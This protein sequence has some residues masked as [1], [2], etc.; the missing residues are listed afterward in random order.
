MKNTETL[1][2]NY[3]FRFVLTKGKYYSGKYLECFIVNN[4]LK[5]NK[6]GIAVSKKIGKA[7]K[8][9]YLKRIIRENYRLNEENVGIGK[10]IVF[11]IK[12]KANINEINFSKIE[13]DMLEI[14]N[15]VK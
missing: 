1:K 6:I 8:R 13:S 5:K 3:E 9:N 11:L 4:N 14:L 12:K 10:S 15:E 7:V 2:K